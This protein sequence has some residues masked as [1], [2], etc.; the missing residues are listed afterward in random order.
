MQLK[1]PLTFNGA[2]LN[3]LTFHR[4]RVKEIKAINTAFELNQFE[5]GMTALSLLCG[6]DRKTLDDLDYEDM[7]AAMEEMKS[8]LPQ[9]VPPTA[10]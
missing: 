2:P 10:G 5:G 4:A 1:F 7:V 9:P 6:V 8:F 3:E